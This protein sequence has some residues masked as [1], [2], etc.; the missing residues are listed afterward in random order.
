VSIL[1]TD[2]FTDVVQVLGELPEDVPDNIIQFPVEEAERAVAARAGVGIAAE[3][4]EEVAA[5]V[6]NL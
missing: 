2:P 3:E 1:R 4:G 6:A 5:F